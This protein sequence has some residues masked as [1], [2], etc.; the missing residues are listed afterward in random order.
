MNYNQHII[1][2]AY[3][4]YYSF[5]QQIPQNNIN[6]AQIY[7]NNNI[8]NNNNAF[9]NMNGYNIIPQRIPQGIQ[10]I[11]IYP[12]YNNGNFTNYLN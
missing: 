2:N 12:Q 6:Q 11:P 5:I 7:Y 3:T 8:Y 9:R 1:P 10:Q 4:N